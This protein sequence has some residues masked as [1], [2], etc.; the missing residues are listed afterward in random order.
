M[1]SAQLGV[2]Y[3]GFKVSDARF[4]GL[5]LTPEFRIY[6]KK[7]A[8]DGFYIAPYFSYHEFIF[9]KYFRLLQRHH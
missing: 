2:A 6:P 3:M 7:N 1:T 9:K 8:I 4:S 5:I